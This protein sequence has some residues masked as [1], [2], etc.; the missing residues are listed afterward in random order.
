MYIKGFVSLFI[1]NNAFLLI[2]YIFYS[3]LVIKIDYL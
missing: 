1:I 3:I 2:L